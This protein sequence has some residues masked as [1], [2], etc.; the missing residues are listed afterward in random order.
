MQSMLAPLV[1]TPECGRAEGTPCDRVAPE[2]ACTGRIAPAAARNG[3]TGPVTA[4]TD[5]GRSGGSLV[6]RAHSRGLVVHPYTFR[7]EVRNTVLECH[8]FTLIELF[9]S[10]VELTAVS[11]LTCRTA[12]IPASHCPLLR[13]GHH[14]HFILGPC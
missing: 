2:Q 12:P 9:L 7:N 1:A 5:W 14:R 13:T 3:S 4:P 11:R 6:A 10:R 8:T